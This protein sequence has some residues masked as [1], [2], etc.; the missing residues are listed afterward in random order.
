MKMRY[1]VMLF[2]CY[3]DKETDKKQ[4]LSSLQD[5]QNY[6][7]YS[8]TNYVFLNFPASYWRGC[9]FSRQRTPSLL[10]PVPAGGRWWPEPCTLSLRS[11]TSRCPWRCRGWSLWQPREGN[12]AVSHC[13]ETATYTRC[14]CLP[15]K[16]NSNH[17]TV[18]SPPWV[19]G[20]NNA[21]RRAS[22]WGRPPETEGGFSFEACWRRCRNVAEIKEKLSEAD[23]FLFKSPPFKSQ[24]VTHHATIWW[25]KWDNGTSIACGNRTNTLTLELQSHNW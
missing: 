22:R 9:C 11:A 21:R 25:G 5:N 1:E 24:W 8:T 13:H 23:G 18:S 12:P 2:L 16:R 6:Q 15:P 3:T 14:W 10:S 7:L 19:S 17:A 4:F 20:K